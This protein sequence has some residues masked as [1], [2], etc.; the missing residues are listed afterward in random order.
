M[1]YNYKSNFKKI[2]RLHRP[3]KFKS[4]K[5]DWNLITDF[6]IIWCTD[7]KYDIHFSQSRKDFSQNGFEYMSEKDYFTDSGGK[8]GIFKVLLSVLFTN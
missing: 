8:V 7:F 4:W 1:L 5:S 6:N 3:A 2:K